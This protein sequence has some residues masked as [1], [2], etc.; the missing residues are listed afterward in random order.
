[1]TGTCGAG[2]GWGALGGDGGLAL[3][4]GVWLFMSSL[5]SGTGMWSGGGGGVAVSEGSRGCCCVGGGAGGGRRGDVG[6]GGCIVLTARVV[7]EK[8]PL[9]LASG[10]QIWA[11]NW[12]LYK[13]KDSGAL[14]D[15]HLDGSRY[16]I[17]ISLI[18]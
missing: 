13:K 6:I 7:R 9:T 16:L 10:A 8:G 18:T 2:W 12:F 11:T 14:F 5:Q 3:P 1:M 17:V 4:C 15:P